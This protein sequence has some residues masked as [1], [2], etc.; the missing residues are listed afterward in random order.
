MMK[1]AKPGGLKFAEI[2]NAPN[3]ATKVILGISNER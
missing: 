2:I 1:T 3:D